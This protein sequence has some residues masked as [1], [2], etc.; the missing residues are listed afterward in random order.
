MLDESGG[1]TI[2]LGLLRGVELRIPCDNRLWMDYPGDESAQSLGESTHHYAIMPHKNDWNTDQIYK[3]ALCF[4]Q[5]LKPCQFGKQNGCL[6]REKSFLEIENSHLVLG[7]IKKSDLRESVI[8]R[9]F[10]PS[11]A[12]QKTKIKCG[13]PFEK[14]YLNQLNETALE[15]LPVEGNEIQ[16]DVSRGK[17]VTIE[18]YERLD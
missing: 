1:K 2:A 7:A 12:D 18:C 13:F 8:V 9:I 17:I 5:P 15:E 16:L 11:K 6:P 3:Y 14:A 4:N 10:N